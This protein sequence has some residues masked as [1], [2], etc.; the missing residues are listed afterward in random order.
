MNENDLLWWFGVLHTDGYVYKKDDSIRE[1]RLRV[2][3]QSMMML[4]K[5][6]SILDSLTE[7][8]HKILKEETYDKRYKKYWTS[9]SIREGSSSALNEL[10]QKLPTRSLYF[11]SEFEGWLKEKRIGAYLAG[12]IDGDGC[13]QIR[14]RYFDK[15]YE[16]LLKIS[17]KTPQKL[18]TIQQL[19]LKNM[20]PK[21]YVTEY[22]NHSDLWIYINKE[23]EKWLRI[24]VLP[25]LTLAHKIE[26]L[27]SGSLGGEQ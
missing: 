5:W 10:I 13:I 6:K 24:K 12:V 15:G 8:E 25:H 9:Y 18:F 20:M 7:K 2:G 17:D 14:K 26:R 3:K 19:L 22:K 4:I 16:K 23:F 11:N 21:G 1:L 27:S